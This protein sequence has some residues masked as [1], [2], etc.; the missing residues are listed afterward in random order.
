[1]DIVRNM[2]QLLLNEH[3]KDSPSTPATIGVNWV[4]NFV[5]W[6]KTIKSKYRRKYDYER[7]KCEDPKVLNAWFKRV[8]TTIAKYG[9]LVED[10][11]NF[12][13]TSFQMGV[14]TTTKVVT[15]SRRHGRSPIT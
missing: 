5:N 7:A 6:H 8:Q 3:M 2:A 10:I 12:D 11:Y 15:S 4:R 1:V 13:K 9:V 14:A